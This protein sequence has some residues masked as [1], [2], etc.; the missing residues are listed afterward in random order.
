MLP[1]LSANQII[2]MIERKGDALAQP[3]QSRGSSPFSRRPYL[4]PRRLT[5]L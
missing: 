3:N 5:C 4:M 2:V 1:A